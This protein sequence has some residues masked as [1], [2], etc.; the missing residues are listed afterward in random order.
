[1]HDEEHAFGSPDTG[2][3]EELEGIERLTLRS[4]GIDIGSS[5]THTIV[6]RLTLRREGAGLSAR[7]T[8]AGRQELYRSPILLTPYLSA[9]RIDTREVIRFVE[10][11]YGEAGIAPGDIDTGAVIITGE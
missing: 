4:V 2:A 11:C 6:S 7:F 10:R 9:T 3:G 5:T 1:M 8:V